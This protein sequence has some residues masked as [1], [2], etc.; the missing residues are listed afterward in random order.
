M[1]LPI[2]VGNSASLTC[3]LN[4]SVHMAIS[5]LDHENPAPKVAIDRYDDYFSVPYLF[6]LEDIFC[7]ELDKQR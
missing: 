1:K 7:V 5:T 4:R 3:M 6:S 2:T